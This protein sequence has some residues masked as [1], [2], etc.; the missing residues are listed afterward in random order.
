MASR[1]KKYAFRVNSYNTQGTFMPISKRLFDEC[2][3]NY[4]KTYKE[5]G[6][7]TDDIHD[8]SEYHIDIKEF[9]DDG[10]TFI[11]HT[12]IIGDGATTIFLYEFTCKDRYCFKN[13]KEK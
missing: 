12:Y 2:L 5:L 6:P 4:Q 1:K 8:S 3:S 10:G 7:E 9:T 13:R 11:Q